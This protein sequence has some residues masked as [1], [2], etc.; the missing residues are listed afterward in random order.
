M[1]WQGGGGSG[2]GSVSAATSKEPPS[3]LAHSPTYLARAG[4]LVTRAAGDASD[5]VGRQVELGQRGIV[6]PQCRLIGLHLYD[7]L[8][9]VGWRAWRRR[10]PGGRGSAAL[11]VNICHAATN[12]CHHPPSPVFLPQV[13]PLDERGGLQEAFNMRLDELRVVDIAFLGELVVLAGADSLYC[14]ALPSSFQPHAFTLHCLP[15]CRC[16][17]A[18]G[19]AAPTIAV[20][21]EDT[22]EQRHVKTYEVSLRDKVCRA[23]M[24]GAD[25]RVLH[26]CMHAGDF[27]WCSASPLPGCCLDLPVLP[28]LCVQELIEGP[29]RQSNLDAGGRAE[30]LCFSGADSPACVLA[31]PLDA[32]LAEVSQPAV[33]VLSPR[34]VPSCPSR[35]LRPLQAAACSSLCPTAAAQWWW[36]RACSPSSPPRGS[37]LQP[38]SQP[39]SRHVSVLP[40]IEPSQLRLLGVYCD[41]SPA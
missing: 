17:S 16:L 6:D 1:A 28:L 11:S 14:K 5:R 40:C 7:G 33:P 30:E 15:H 10:A 38:S 19:C 32:V 27:C 21:Y 20:L 26:G 37:A 4:E 31:P 39:W 3:S 8:F 29:W 41:P 9:K 24:Q 25:G 22:K 18:D 12:I 35:L 13:I 34:P 2:C 36:E 23:C